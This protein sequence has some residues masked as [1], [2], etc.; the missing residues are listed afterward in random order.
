MPVYQGGPHL[1]SRSLFNYE[2]LPLPFSEVSKLR[3]SNTELISS[4]YLL[5]LIDHL[6]NWILA[7]TLH[8]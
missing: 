3:H 7:E 4:K 2:Q 8:S 5:N 1:G 6:T